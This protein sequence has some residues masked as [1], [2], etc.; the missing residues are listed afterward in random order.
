M[1]TQTILRALS[2]ALPI[3]CGTSRAQDLF[4][5][6]AASTKDAIIHIRPEFLLTTNSQFTLEFIDESLTLTK[7]NVQEPFAAVPEGFLGGVVISGT[8]PVAIVGMSAGTGGLETLPAVSTNL[9]WQTGWVHEV[10][11]DGGFLHLIHPGGTGDV[12]TVKIHYN[13][14]ISRELLIPPGGQ[15]ITTNATEGH[16]PTWHGWARIDSD[17]PLEGAVRIEKS[18]GGCSFLPSLPGRDSTIVYPFLP[19]NFEGNL[20]GFQL[21]NCSPTSTLDV[22]IQFNTKAGAPLFAFPFAGIPPDSPAGLNAVIDSP[23]ITTNDYYNCTIISTSGQN[24]DGLVEF[25]RGGGTY[26]Q[27]IPRNL[28]GNKAYCPLVFGEPGGGY[29]SSVYVQNVDGGNINDGSFVISGKDEFGTP[30][31]ESGT[32]P[33]LAPN[34]STRIFLG[35]FTSLVQ[36]S[37]VGSAIISSPTRDIA[38]CVITESSSDAFAYTA[39]SENTLGTRVVL[40]ALQDQVPDVTIT[41][42][43]TSSTTTITLEWEPVPSATNYSVLRSASP[44]SLESPGWIPVM[45]TTVSE[46][47]LAA[48][49]L[50]GTFRVESD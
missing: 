6:G 31:T 9:L 44:V 30:I 37:F 43:Y 41:N 40:P 21:Q 36:N 35:A 28:A 23:L 5:D 20:A 14:G 7:P 17:Q 2:L 33:V 3:L 45:T 15:I 38:A 49:N 42:L 13:D 18:G 34:A 29:V 19:K 11:T 32:L 22:A 12:A 26:Y 8:N 46:V 4:I 27:A 10:Q 39:L 24:I 16:A 1:K 50:V 48:T 25:N 47:S